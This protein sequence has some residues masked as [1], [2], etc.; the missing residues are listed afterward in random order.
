MNNSLEEIKKYILEHDNYLIAGHL[1]PDF[2]CVFSQLSLC[3]LL[4]NLN[5]NCVTINE[6]P[7][8]KNIFKKYSN[9][10]VQTLSELKYDKNWTLIIVDCSTED[11]I[12]HFSVLSEELTT[13][14]IDHHSNG[15]NHAKYKFIDSSSPSTTILIKELFDSFEMEI[16]KENAQMM[17]HGFC[18]DTGFFR[19]LKNNVGKYLKDCADLTDAGGNLKKCYNKMFYNKS[20]LSRLYLGTMIKRAK[21]YYNGKVIVL[22]ENKSI[23]RK[24]ANNRD[25]DSLYDIIMATENCEAIIFIKYISKIKTVVGLR[26]KD[27]VNVGEIALKF[28]GGGHK[29]AA[30]FSFTGSTKKIKKLVLKEF[31]KINQNCF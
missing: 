26:A 19:H 21:P 11:R 10:F 23:S 9:Q 30:G 2:D 16:S 29:A 5:K 4:K 28:G 3:A 7:F 12:G 18:T 15:E 27:E 13:I 31:E 20:R 1:D 17:L 25:S 14:V 8:L 22:Q 6:G 24:Y